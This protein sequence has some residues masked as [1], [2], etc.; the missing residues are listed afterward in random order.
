MSL[1]GLAR[2]ASLNLLARV[3]TV[4]LGLALM[5]H[6]AR[7]GPAVQGA[8]ALFVTVESV[9]L[10]LGSGFGL[11]LA[12]RISHH[13]E[14]PGGGLRRWLLVS[15][16]FGAVA[17][18]VLLAMAA[19]ARSAPYDRLHLMALA[20]PLLLLVSTASGLWLGQGRMGPM[21]LP[22]VAA[23]ALVLGALLLLPRQGEDL[24]G[25]V[26]AAWVAAKALVGVGTAAAALRA[27]P[28]QAPQ[29]WRAVRRDARFVLEIGVTNV[30]SLLNYRVT[31]FLVERH[32]GLAAAGVYSVA[33][34]VAELLWL[35]S[36]A[37][38]MSAYHRIGQPDTAGA[39]RTSRQAARL[40]MAVAAV[41]APLLWGGAALA[42][43]RVLGP[44]YAGVLPPLAALLPGIAAYAAA[45]SLS[46]FFTNHLGRPHL[47]GL[48]AA[49]SLALNTLG[50]LLA[51][52]RWGAL[53]AAASTSAAYLCAIGVAWLLFRQAAQPGAA[54]AGVAQPRQ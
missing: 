23:P 15:V 51:V 13:Q 7:L 8:F 10:T 30:V 52:P 26:L 50:C 35:L 41:A 53:G 24:L 32:E 28:A 11:A 27:A 4:A 40:N 19:Q 25:P 17:A 21:N 18:L 44:A 29:P 22:Q 54:G 5:V 39:A 46:A 49:L 42:L 37:L 6:V 43:P 2:G 1:A 48:I 47:S 9:L 34:Q 33:V 20:A 31:L 3:A 38:T 45:S 14:A 12:R 36:S 16:G